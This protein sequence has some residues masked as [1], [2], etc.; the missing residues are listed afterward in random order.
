MRLQVIGESV[1]QIQ[2]LDAAFLKAYREIQ[3]NKI[4]KASPMAPE[5]LS[6][7]AYQLTSLTAAVLNP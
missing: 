7:P 2:K 1:K 6:L 4:A 3:W 5:S